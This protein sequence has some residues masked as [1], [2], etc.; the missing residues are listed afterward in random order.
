MGSCYLLLHS[1]SKNLFRFEDMSV[2]KELVRYELWVNVPVAIFY[3]TEDCAVV[4]RCCPLADFVC[5]FVF[6]ILLFKGNNMEQ[7]T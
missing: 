5:L 6:A 2:V 4:D 3:P 7:N 1:M